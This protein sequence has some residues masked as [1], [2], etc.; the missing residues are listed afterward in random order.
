M[1]DEVDSIWSGLF[2]YYYLADTP[3]DQ[4]KGRLDVTLFKDTTELAGSLAGVL[5]YSKVESK[6]EF[7][8]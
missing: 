6:K 7:N 1:A 8:E 5:L 4:I 3:Q 2:N